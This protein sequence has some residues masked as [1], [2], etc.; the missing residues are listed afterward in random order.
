MPCGANVKN[1]SRPKA[2]KDPFVEVIPL[3]RTEGEGKDVPTARFW[4]PIS[5]RTPFLLTVILV[6]FGLVAVLQVLLLQSQR[7][8]GVLFASK[9]KDLPLKRSFLYLY[10]PTILSVLYGLVWSWIDLDAKRMEPYRQLSKLRGA[11]A[12]D[13][14]LLHYPVDFLATVPLSS[15]R[16]KHW[17]VFVA[18]T[19]LV[20]VSWGITPLQAAIFATHTVEK[21]CG[22]SMAVSTHY[23]TASE[24]QTRVT[25]NYT[26]SVFGIAWLNQSLPSYM[27]RQAALV[28]FV[29]TIS[30]G[31]QDEETW[32]AAT[33]LYSVDVDCQAAELRA[34]K[35]KLFS[36][37]SYSQLYYTSSQGCKIPYP[38]GQTGNDTVGGMGL[39]QIKQYTAL[40][41]GYGNH[42]GLA[43]FYLSQYCP[44]NA[45]NVFLAA[46]AQNKRHENDTVKAATTLFCEPTY[47]RRNV[48][49]TI[50]RS[51]LGILNYTATDSK[52][53]V[54]TDVFNPRRLEWQMN[55]A[56][57]QQAVRGDVP[58]STWPDQ[59][60]RLSNL[61]ISLQ[62][63]G[64]ELPM[65]A[66]M[67]IGAD[68]RPLQDYLNPEVLR[69]SYQAAYGLLFARAMVDVLQPPA[70]FDHA[71]VVN[72]TRSYI[73]Q[74]VY[75]VP[76]FTYVVEGLLVV[77][78]L[79]ALVQ[80]VLSI[81]KH[82]NL[83]SDPGSIAALMTLVARDSDLLRTLRQ[84]D[85][86]SEDEMKM[87]LDGKKYSLQRTDSGGCE[88]RQITDAASQQ[89]ADT[90]FD[91][92]PSFEK[93]TTRGSTPRELTLP[94]GI[95]F[96]AMLIA[97]LAA[98]IYLY[99][100]NKLEGLALPSRN[101]FVRQM[102]ENYVPTVLATLI[103]P[104][105]VLLNRLLC[106]LQPLEDLRKSNSPSSRSLSLNYTSLP[107]QLVVF[108]AAMKKHML[109][110]V[111][112]TMALLANVLAVAFGAMFNEE[113]MLVPK[114]ANITLSYRAEFGDIDGSIGP[115]NVSANV[116][117]GLDQ[118]YMAMSNLTSATPLPAFTSNTQFFVPFSLSSSE[119]GN[120]GVQATT[121][122]FGANL[123]CMPLRQDS[124]NSWRL[125][126]GPDIW[127]DDAVANLSIS[128]NDPAVGS[129]NCEA[130]DITIS[131]KLE[132]GQCPRGRLATE[133][134]T[135]MRA[136]ASARASEVKACQQL[137]VAAWIRS[138]SPGSCMF[139][140]AL[141]LT[142]DDTTIIAC[143]PSIYASSA[144][145]TVDGNGMVQA[146][147][148][149]IASSTDVQTY[150]SDDPGQ[151]VLQANNF[152]I[153]R[154]TTSGAGGGG[155]WHND[156]FPSDWNN[157]VMEHIAGNSTFLNPSLPP[158]AADDVARLFEEMYQKLFAIWLG[159]NHQKFLLPADAPNAAVTGKIL[160]V[161]TRI[162]V[163]RPMFVVA[164]VILSLYIL[165]TVV[166]YARRP[167]RHIPLLPTT[168]AAVIAMFA[169]DCGTSDLA[170][171]MSMPKKQDKSR[172]YQE[173]RRL[174]WQRAVGRW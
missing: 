36:G 99:V 112:C 41:A 14:L 160:R 144:E 24:Q 127:S 6:S 45:S 23:L 114:T 2:L 40:Y 46:F 38:Y 66:G 58:A 141:N 86:S 54:P 139:A 165:V 55:S 143:L 108:K 20:L 173:G 42:D 133:V 122:A 110:S 21:A 153:G 9:I 135:A 126:V 30:A 167:G 124:A 106:M 91:A 19:A 101:R 49:A 70:A 59:T 80:L 56:T 78:G 22:E 27:S 170:A 67:A 168:M 96:A 174:F 10:F 125:A 3:P 119:D 72:G 117:D 146:V 151:L 172:R 69:Q 8:D 11:T 4:K 25:A 163:S 95:T 37:G 76:G 75:M 61:P 171:A 18:S 63:N 104:M 156:S 145:V 53:T 1:T 43:D 89:V 158:P 113:P 130:L 64:V 123:T 84:L 50:R 48:T 87:S 29:P 147:S 88:L 82:T 7:N 111:V 166:L 28:P 32:T 136:T 103:E 73:T 116:G 44:T 162:T 115:W 100:A 121:T 149:S 77:V 150:F 16:R 83:D 92:S 137:V 142:D 34:E 102:L 164:E 140:R 161:D 132:R 81:H 155:V 131:S 85:Q 159:M 65:M 5:L 51:D 52:Q 138:P 79:L 90:A 154:R 71:A 62:Y 47:Y 57:Q 26:Y 74:A 107:P 98:L 109:L 105:W 169:A 152:L 39:D 60:E 120:T 157:Y 13:S 15:L 118:F 97:L 148:N 35:V 129:L 31:M 94:A 128:W 68:Q 12:E 33:T 134:V 17:P 93:S